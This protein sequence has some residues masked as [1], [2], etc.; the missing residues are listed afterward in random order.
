MLA[1][2]QKPEMPVWSAR[3][4]LLTLTALA[5]M[6][7]VPRLS[8]QES[9][10]DAAR[11]IRVNKENA[12]AA[13]NG[14][15]KLSPAAA[16]LATTMSLISETD[17][18]KYAEGIR[19]LLEQERFRVLDDVADGER[20]SKV[21]FPG[22]DWK[23]HTFYEALA[24]PG[25]RG[26]GVVAD[27]NI[28]RDRM[29]RWM[30]GQPTS[31]TARVALAQAE[32]LYAWQLRGPGAA[33]T[34][35]PDRHDLFLERLK[36][37]EAVLNQASSLQAKCPEWYN[38]MLQVGRD[39]GWEVDDLNTL[40]QRAAAFEPKY[41]YIYQQQALTLT[42]LW[43]GKEGDVEKFA[44]DQAN[45]IGGKPGDMLYWLIAETIIGNP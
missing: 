24:S 16:D 23:L 28:Y 34:I 14:Q 8:A 27:W 33:G 25:G 26:R 12:T 9:L 36:V 15:K 7:A 31:I 30:T 44:E 5:A 42:P 3:T 29:T 6:V 43:R 37:A 32:L 45:R 10:G 2:M 35:A 20:A 17:P 38:V 39:K 4:L 18:E 41:F 22:G 11:R 19:L 40:L 13:Q 21:R 1:I